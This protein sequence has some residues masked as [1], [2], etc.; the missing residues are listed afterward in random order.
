MLKITRKGTSKCQY[1]LYCWLALGNNAEKYVRLL[2]GSIIAVLGSNL[3]SFQSNKSGPIF[4]FN[5]IRLEIIRSNQKV[6]IVSMGNF[7]HYKYPKT[8]AGCQ[9][10]I[11]SLCKI[12]V[13]IS[14]AFNTPKNLKIRKYFKKFKR[15]LIPFPKKNKIYYQINNFSG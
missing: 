6:R 13:A 11:P 3:I 4:V 5:F 12:S 1:R 9:H 7:N 15:N 10:C 2:A 8:I 14:G